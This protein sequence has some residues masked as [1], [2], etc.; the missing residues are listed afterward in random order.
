MNAQ[1]DMKSAEYELAQLI[2]CYGDQAPS[3]KKKSLE[4]DKRVFADIFA[5]SRTRPWRLLKLRE[6]FGKRITVFYRTL[7][8][9]WL[10]KS[11]K[12]IYFS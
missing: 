6:I 1:K 3:G 2:S 4:D 12:S 10:L 9:L 7:L 5:N 11:I 8:E